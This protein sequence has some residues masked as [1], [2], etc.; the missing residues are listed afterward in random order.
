MLPAAAMCYM[1]YIGDGGFSFF[2][3]SAGGWV[4][5]EIEVNAD[6]VG[7]GAGAELGNKSLVMTTTT[8]FFFL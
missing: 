4:G 1:S 8:L 5:V 2:T 3:F 7:V 6:S